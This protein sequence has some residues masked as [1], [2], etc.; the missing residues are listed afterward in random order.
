MISTPIVKN[1]NVN[2]VEARIHAIPWPLYR[3]I[4]GAD[5][6]DRDPAETIER[7]VRE[8]VETADGSDVTALA[9]RQQMTRL[10]QLAVDESECP[11][12]DF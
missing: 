5:D 8:C 7:V 11:K 12:P 4:Y 9:T 2:G 10:F 1:V 6:A 3:E